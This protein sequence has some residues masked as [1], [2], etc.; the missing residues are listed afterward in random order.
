M[1]GPRCR[2][3]PRDDKMRATNGE[4]KER[5]D[6]NV[7]LAKPDDFITEVPGWRARSRFTAKIE[8]ATLETSPTPMQ[9]CR[10]AWSIMLRSGPASSR[11]SRI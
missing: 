1:A 2:G 11:S 3:P 10:L 5:I 8:R 9:C 4:L 7:E 6:L